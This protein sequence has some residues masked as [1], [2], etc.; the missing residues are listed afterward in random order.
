M[1][2]LLFKGQ[3]QFKMRSDNTCRDFIT[4]LILHVFF[5]NFVFFCLRGSMSAGFRT[6]TVHCVCQKAVAGLCTA[7]RSV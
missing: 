4:T 6:V 1:S 5:S 7:K 3:K 2:V